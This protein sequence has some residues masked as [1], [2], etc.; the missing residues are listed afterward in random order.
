MDDELPKVTREEQRG[1]VKGARQLAGD[2][3]NN[4]RRNRPLCF[5]TVVSVYNDWVLTLMK[6]SSNV[7]QYRATSPM[8]SDRSTLVIY[9]KPLALACIGASNFPRDNRTN[10]KRL[11][12][13]C[14]AVCFACTLV[15]CHVSAIQGVDHHYHLATR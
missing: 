12:A 14:L 11:L 2:R 10:K 15:S 3:V 8:I 7:V 13:C 4:L 9:N 5:E 1:R 6:E